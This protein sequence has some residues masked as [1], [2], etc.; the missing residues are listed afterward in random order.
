MFEKTSQFQFI[1]Y[2]WIYKKLLK[3]N[4]WEKKVNFS[5]Y[6]IYKFIVQ[7]INIIEKNNLYKKYSFIS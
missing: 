6:I 2:L 7:K 5:S 4:I 1:H 3:L